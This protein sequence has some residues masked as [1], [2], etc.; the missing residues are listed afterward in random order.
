MSKDPFCA[1]AH[2]TDPAHLETYVTGAN[3]GLQNVVLYISDWSGSAQA[4]TAVLD[5]QSEELHVHAARVGDGYRR[6]IQG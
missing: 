1:K 5:I 2:A 4:S 6:V 3:G